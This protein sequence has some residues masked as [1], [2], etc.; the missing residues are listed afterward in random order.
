L[1]RPVKNMWLAVRLLIAAKAVG[2]SLKAAKL[3]DLLHENTTGCCAIAQIISPTAVDRGP[4]RTISHDPR[5]CSRC[6]PRPATTGVAEVVRRL[7][8]ETAPVSLVVDNGAYDVADDVNHVMAA[9]ARGDRVRLALQIADELVRSDVLK[10]ERFV[11]ELPLGREQ[12]SAAHAVASVWSRRNPHAALIWAQALPDQDTRQLAVHEVTR[13]LVAADVHGALVLVSALTDG[14]GREDAFRSI[15]A[16]WLRADL[17]AALAWVHDM[18]ES[19]TKA[20]LVIFSVLSLKSLD[21][22][23]TWIATFASSERQFT[24][25]EAVAPHWLEMNRTEASRWVEQSALP[26]NRKQR[27]LAR[28]DEAL[29]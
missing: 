14:P 17:A 15:A 2:T 4:A 13:H 16:H 9:V 26:P 6:V 21:G 10:G 20:R 7:R 24:M 5:S 11:A 22:A 12:R 1:D 8:R 23:K 29:D 18:V 28:S 25:I 27:L 19:P 3:A